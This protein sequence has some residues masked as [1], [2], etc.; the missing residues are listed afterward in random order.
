MRALAM[1]GMVTTALMPSIISGSLMRA[2][3]P[4]R[5]ISAGTR[6]RAITALAPA[7]SAILAC[8]GVTTSMMTPPLSISARPRLTSM[9]PVSRVGE[10]LFD[11]A[12]VM[13]VSLRARD[14]A[15]DRIRQVLNAALRRQGHP[16]A[17]GCELDRFGVV[18]GG[19][20]PRRF[21]ERPRPFAFDDLA[22]GVHHGPALADRDRLQRTRGRAHLVGGHQYD[23]VVDGDHLAV[24]V[25]ML[26]AVLRA[27]PLLTDAVVVELRRVAHLD[28]YT[29]GAQTHARRQPLADGAQRERTVRCLRFGCGFVELFRAREQVV[30]RTTTHGLAE[31]AAAPL[32]VVTDVHEAVLDSI[33]L[34]THVGVVAAPAE[35]R[36]L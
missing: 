12:V 14:S 2:T 33:E 19:D 22:V 26:R 9:D 1:T 23:D 28:Q 8:S 29:G 32:R 16:C 7:S 20:G 6:S 25:E 17:T 34:G 13:A 24:G 3:P 21:G 18:A 35:H 31:V 15:G 10:P 27:L 4:S 5:R 30:G 36:F 11:E